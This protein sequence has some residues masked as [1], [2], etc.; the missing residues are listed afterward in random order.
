GYAALSFVGL[1]PAALI[2]VDLRALLERAR[3]MVELSGTTSRAHESPAVRLGAALAAFAKAG[4]DKV[5]F[6]LSDKI[7]AL[8]VWLEQ[9]VAES[10]GKDGTGLVPVMAEPLGPPASYS[11]DRLFVALTLSD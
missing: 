2:G 1:V 10:L 3:V 7:R 5:T 9:L 8:G 4:R 11:S 6:V